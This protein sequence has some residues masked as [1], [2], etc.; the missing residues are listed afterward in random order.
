M[1]ILYV[2]IFYQLLMYINTLRFPKFGYDEL[3]ISANVCS[4]VN[5]SIVTLYSLYALFRIHCDISIFNVSEALFLMNSDNMNIIA[6]LIVGYFI[7]DVIY[8][9]LC[10]R[11]LSK[12]NIMYLVH[13]VIFSLIL[14]WFSV[15]GKYHFFGLATLLTESSTII[16][17]MHQYCRYYAKIYKNNL[18]NEQRDIYNIYAYCL[19]FVF[20]IVFICSR[21]IVTI[22]LILGYY[23]LIYKTEPLL[24]LLAIFIFMLN[25]IWLKEIIKIIF[26]YKF[27]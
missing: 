11:T 26:N 9:L 24:F 7:S 2:F 10:T 1:L 19:F 5:A 23:E 18:L 25:G 16:I 12:N 14:Y 6:N 20:I 15:S 17:N 3:L 8:L 21:F 22:M 4:F 27:V 13:H